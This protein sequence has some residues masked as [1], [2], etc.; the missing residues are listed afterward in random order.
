MWWCSGTAGVPYTSGTLVHKTP[1]KQMKSIVLL[2]WL[3]CSHVDS[4]LS[5]MSLC[6]ALNSSDEFDSFIIE[7]DTTGLRQKNKLF[8]FE[9]SLQMSICCWGCKHGRKLPLKTRKISCPPVIYECFIILSEHYFIG[10]WACFAKTA[11]NKYCVNNWLKIFI[12]YHF[13]DTI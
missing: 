11:R 8:C 3:W 6:T 10:N 1:A 7:T 9:G 12:A 13:L 4:R 2:L 5:G